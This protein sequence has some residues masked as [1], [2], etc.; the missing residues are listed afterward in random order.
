MLLRTMICTPVSGIK[1]CDHLDNTNY[2]IYIIQTLVVHVILDVEAIWLLWLR[3][4]NIAWRR[5]HALT[6]SKA[7]ARSNCQLATLITNY[8]LENHIFLL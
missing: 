3:Y 7:K 6:K 8:L 5:P 2:R 4:R 1:I